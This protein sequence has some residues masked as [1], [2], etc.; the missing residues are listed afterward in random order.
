MLGVTVETTVGI[1]ILEELVSTTSLA[2]FEVGD[3]E[4]ILLL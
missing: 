4:G 2:N 1:I 3:D